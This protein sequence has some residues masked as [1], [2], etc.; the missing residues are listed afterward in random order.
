[1]RP[2]V[3]NPLFAPIEALPGLGEKSAQPLHRLLG[4]APRVLD[5][6]FH[7]PSGLVDRR[8]R[9]KI[10]DAQPGGVV[11]LEITVEEHH[12][13]P[14]NRP[15]APHRVVVTDGT[16]WVTLI[17]FGSNKSYVERQLPVGA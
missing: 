17:F 11:T 9:P 16:G 1:M 6:L 13:P 14:R 3:L 5:V 8:Y 4:P 2:S 7:L 15:R 10:A 12:A